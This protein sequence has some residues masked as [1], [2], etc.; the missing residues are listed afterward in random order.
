MFKKIIFVLYL[1]LSFNIINYA[2]SYNI[3][4][5]YNNS[6]NDNVQKYFYT[7]NFINNIKNK[8]I[9]KIIKLLD[10]KYKINFIKKKWVIEWYNKY[11]SALEWLDKIVLK[12]LKNNKYKKYKNLLIYLHNNLTEYIKYI[13]TEFLIEQKLKLY[14]NIKNNSNN[15]PNTKIYLSYINEKIKILNNLKYWLNFN[16]IYNK[17]PNKLKEFLNFI[18][19]ATWEQ[20]E[21]EKIYNLNKQKY[22]KEN[23]IINFK[24]PLISKETIKETLNEYSK[25]W[26][27]IDENNFNKIIEQSNKVINNLVTYKKE[28]LNNLKWKIIPIYFSWNNSV[29]WWWFYLFWNKKYKFWFNEHSKCTF[30]I[31]FDIRNNWIDKFINSLDNYKNNINFYLIT[32]DLITLYSYKYTD[33]CMNTKNVNNILH[34]A[35]KNWDIKIKQKIFWKLWW[36]YLKNQFYNLL[37]LWNK[38]YFINKDIPFSDSDKSIFLLQNFNDNISFIESNNNNK[39]IYFNKKYISKY[40]KTIIWYKDWILDKWYSK[41]Y[42]NRWNIIYL[43]NTD[44]LK[45]NL[46]YF[47]NYLKFLLQYNYIIW[48]VNKTLI[49]TSVD[50]I[51][52]KE[53]LKYNKKISN[54][55]KNVI[56]IIYNNDFKYMKDIYKYIETNYTYDNELVNKSF[57]YY[58]KW[59]YE[60]SNEWFDINYLLNNKKWVCFHFALLYS[61]I[62]SLYWVPSWYVLINNKNKKEPWHAFS[63]IYWNFYD[64]TYEVWQKNI[65]YKWLWHSFVEGQ[66]YTYSWVD[67]YYPKNVIKYINKNSKLLKTYKYNIIWF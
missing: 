66:T 26:W 21:L 47:Y 15:N 41:T 54:R 19:T 39:N 29:L 65:Q 14:T 30:S 2:F 43:W 63:I 53:A 24:L 42:I 28:I 46:Y 22:E 67:I 55:I 7:K 23:K 10:E 12:Y 32:K 13:K 38:I 52:P 62:T 34:F 27:T 35:L 50:N 20:N 45:N 59:E 51:Y 18:N 8:K 16:E 6:S 25:N 36:E 40:Y 1:I 5:N 11:I 4:Y 31:S 33:N 57:M 37:L 60:K 64:A 9:K 48:Y 49:N 58:K 3:N 61:F 44:F 17:F 56:E